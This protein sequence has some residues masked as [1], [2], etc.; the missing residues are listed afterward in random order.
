MSYK[1]YSPVT[2]ADF[3]L[4]YPSVH[5]WDTSYKN[6][7]GGQIAD[8]DE[9][10]APVPGWGMN[11]NLAGPA[12]VG[13]GADTSSGSSKYIW[14]GA[15]IVAVAGFVYYTSR[16]KAKTPPVVRPSRAP[17]PAPAGNKPGTYKIKFID[18]S[19]GDDITSTSLQASN[20]ADAMDKADAEATRRGWQVKEVEVGMPFQIIVAVRQ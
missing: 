17:R 3:A 12:R 13:I 6:N 16:A 20:N 5:G 7:Y 14:I 8:W 9:R 10:H 1:T 19:T 2:R 11:P 4:E 18:N 15:A